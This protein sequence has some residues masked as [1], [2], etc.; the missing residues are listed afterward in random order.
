VVIAIIA[1]LIALLLPAVQQAREAARRSTCKNNLKQLGL[2][3][4]N[5]HDVYRQLPIGIAVD[6]S[7]GWGWAWGAYILPYVDQAPLYKTIE[8]NMWTDSGGSTSTNIAAAAA[9]AMPVFECPSAAVSIKLHSG[10]RMQNYAGN[11]GSDSFA[12]DDNAGVLDKNGIF[13]SGSPKPEASDGIEFRD[14]TDGTSNTMM[15]AEKAGNASGSIGNAPCANCSCHVIFSSYLDANP[16]TNEVSE[17]LG[18]TNFGFNT[19]DEKAF[20]SF[21]TGGIQAVMCDGSVKFFSE[22]ISAAVRLAIGS[23]NGGEIEEIP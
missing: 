22:N 7:S 10:R 20:H 18:G 4:H 1:I 14:I 3:M 15:I 2:A 23:R 9:L 16:P 19:N 11:A 21:H 12:T 13:L 8:P 5:H 17:M 6:G